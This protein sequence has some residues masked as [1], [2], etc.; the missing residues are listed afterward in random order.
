MTN[1]AWPVIHLN[2]TVPTSSTY[3]ER[4]YY[5]QRPKPLFTINKLNMLKRGA[6]NHVENAGEIKHHS[7]HKAGRLPTP[8]GSILWPC[9][10]SLR[11]A[12]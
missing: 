9:T 11:F 8:V 2:L 7:S 12:E 1:D 3:R 5:L 10:N 4:P 6:E